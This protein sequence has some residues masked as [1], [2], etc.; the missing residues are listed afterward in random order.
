MQPSNNGYTNSR[1][2]KKRKV[3]TLLAKAH[4]VEASL[5]EVRVVQN[6]FHEV[7]H[8]ITKKIDTEIH[9]AFQE[10]QLQESLSFKVR[11]RG[12]S[13]PWCTDE[14]TL[15]DAIAKLNDILQPIT[16]DPNTLLD[17]RHKQTWAT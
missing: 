3:K 4:T 2:C 11:I 7:T 8:G 14:D 13:S 10:R 16:I 15:E 6:K 1:A 17:Q 9:A 5:T 12:L